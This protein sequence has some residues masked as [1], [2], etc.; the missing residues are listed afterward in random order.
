MLASTLL[1]MAG[2]VSFSMAGYVLQDDYNSNSFFDMF[3][4]FTVR[5]CLSYL[6]PP[7]LTRDRVVTRP[8][9]MS[10]MSINELRKMRV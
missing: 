3:D 2:F 1:T 10:P 6:L 4:F 9:D 5:K 7:P 8:M